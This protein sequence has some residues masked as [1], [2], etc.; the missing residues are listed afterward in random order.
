M[1]V[2]NSSTWS[3]VKNMKSWRV[4]RRVGIP[5]DGF[6]S[7][8]CLEHAN[9]LF[10]MEDLPLQIWD[11]HRIMINY[12][13]T[14]CI[15]WVLR[16]AGKCHTVTH[17]S[18]CKVLESRTPKASRPYKFYNY[19]RDWSALQLELGYWRIQWYLSWNGHSDSDSESL[20]RK[21]EIIQYH[22]ST[23]ALVVVIECKR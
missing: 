8:F 14:A 18:S 7:G 19:N 9:G 1:G 4:V 17:T 13:N 22:L 15:R 12:A 5:L 2:V 20:T 3:Y 23:I 11:F 10:I 21:T 16:N 6:S